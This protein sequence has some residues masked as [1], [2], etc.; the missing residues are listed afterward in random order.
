MQNSVR[1]QIKTMSGMFQARNKLI[2]KLLV[3]FSVQN[4]FA[5]VLQLLIFTLLFLLSY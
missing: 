3:F 4:I 1:K 2:L 5:D